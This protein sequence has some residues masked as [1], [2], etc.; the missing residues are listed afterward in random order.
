[1]FLFGP[2][3]STGTF[4]LGLFIV[5]LADFASLLLSIL[6]ADLDLEIAN[7]LK[8][9]HPISLSPFG[10]CNSV[11]MHR[12]S[13]DLPVCKLEVQHL[14]YFCCGKSLALIYFE[15]QVL[16]SIKKKG[17]WFL[18]IHKQSLMGSCRHKQLF[19]IALHLL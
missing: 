14:S 3:S 2:V 9:Q 12:T 19:C 13:A 16:Y 7:K 6:L 17:N 11:F 18:R 4:H 8:M 5:T 15:C 10:K 1:M